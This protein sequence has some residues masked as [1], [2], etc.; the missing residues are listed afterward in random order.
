MANFNKTLEK[1]SNDALID[2]LKNDNSLYNTLPIEIVE[3][4][5]VK[6]LVIL[7]ILTDRI[8]DEMG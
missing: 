1:L 4:L 5:K 7:Q 6:D 2:I 3:Y 8:M